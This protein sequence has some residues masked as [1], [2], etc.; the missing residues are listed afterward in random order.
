MYVILNLAIDGQWP[1][2]P[3]STTPVSGRC[4]IEYV[5]AYA[6]AAGG[7]SDTGGSGAGG[8]SGGDGCGCGLDGERDRAPATVVLVGL[9]IGV[10]GRRRRRALLCHTRRS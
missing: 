5:R 3:D 7:G 10:L 2:A 4:Q 6:P 9:V 1:G 8:S